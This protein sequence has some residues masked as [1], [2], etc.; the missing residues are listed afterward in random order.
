MAWIFTSTGTPNDS[1]NLSP[2]TYAAT[3]FTLK[4]VLKQAGWVVKASSDGSTY[5]SSGDQ[6]TTGNAGAGGMNNSSAWFRIQSPAGAGGRE[7]TYQRGTT[8]SNFRRKVSHSVGFVTGGSATVTPS[9]T[10][11][12]VLSGA[13][14]DASPTFTAYSTDASYKAHIGAD[15]AAP[16]DFHLMTPV[17]GGGNLGHKFALYTMVAGSYPTEDVAPYIWADHL[18]LS[19]GHVFSPLGTTSTP[20]ANGAGRGY[21]KKGL[22]GEAFV[23]FRTGSYGSATTTFTHIKTVVNPYSG[24]DEILQMIVWRASTDSEAGWKGA[25][26]INSLAWQGPSRTNGDYVDIGGLRY[27][28]W[29]EVAFRFA[30][31]IIPVT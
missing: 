9:A 29:N 2:A 18:S 3:M 26:S 27:A 20:S 17:N 28:Y 30:P 6:I 15:N 12:Q 24:K 11:E 5:N 19:G 1:V 21:F 25:I 10:D 14:T 16:Y 31:G 22:S 8:S 13:G 4:E 23:V 7:F